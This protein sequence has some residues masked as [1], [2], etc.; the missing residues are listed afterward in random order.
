M[1][2]YA[3]YKSKFNSITSNSYFLRLNFVGLLGDLLEGL[4]VDLLVD[5]FVDFMLATLLGLVD[6]LPVDLLTAL[7][8]DLL[9]DWFGD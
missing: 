1:L 7:I 3:L 5:L 6:F 2:Y 8:E 9:P 4:S